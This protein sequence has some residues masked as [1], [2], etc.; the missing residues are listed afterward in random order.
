MNTPGVSGRRAA[1]GERRAAKA[2]LS[3]APKTCSIRVNGAIDRHGGRGHG[4][5]AEPGTLASIPAGVSSRLVFMIT[6]ESRSRAI[7]SL[8]QEQALRDHGGAVEVVYVLNPKFPDL[9]PPGRQ[10]PRALP[11]SD[12]ER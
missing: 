4:V 8:R 10:S 3:M 6:K 7:K 12:R 11:R 2:S 5:T 1:S 9:I